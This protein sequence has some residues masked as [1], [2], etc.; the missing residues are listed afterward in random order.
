M[1]DYVCKKNVH[2]KQEYC[3]TTK[4]YLVLLLVPVKPMNEGQSSFSSCSGRTGTVVLLLPTDVLTSF[5]ALA[6]LTLT[7]LMLC[8]PS[9]VTKKTIC[10]QCL[11]FLTIEVFRS[12][13]WGCPCS[14]VVP[15][16]TKESRLKGPWR[17]LCQ[18]KKLLKDSRQK[19]G[20]AAGRTAGE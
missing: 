13:T 18:L 16:A 6:L 7:G 15:E 19:Q 10:W 14:F 9:R 8:V 5:S 20:K 2:E 11:V 4:T 12:R 3:Q 1:S 17:V